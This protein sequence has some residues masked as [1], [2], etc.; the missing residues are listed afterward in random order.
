MKGEESYYFH[1][2]VPFCFSTGIINTQKQTCMRT[3]THT[4]IFPSRGIFE[5]NLKKK[6]RRTCQCMSQHVQTRKTAA[7]RLCASSQVQYYWCKGEAGWSK[8]WRHRNKGDTESKLKHFR[9]QKRKYIYWIDFHMCLVLVSF[10][11]FLPF[12]TSYWWMKICRF[13]M[14]YFTSVTPRE[15][16]LVHSLRKWALKCTNNEFLRR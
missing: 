8:A 2:N 9:T 14:P 10:V 5:G 3:Y 7:L 16:L 13:Q 11:C 1:I 12:L 15:G 4:Y 6:D